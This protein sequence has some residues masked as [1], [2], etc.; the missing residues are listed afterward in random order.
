[1]CVSSCTSAAWRAS[2]STTRDGG[3]ITTTK[4]AGDVRARSVATAAPRPVLQSDP[5]PIDA[6]LVQPDS[7][8]GSIPHTDSRSDTQ[9]NQEPATRQFQGS[10]VPSV[11]RASFGWVWFGASNAGHWNSLRTMPWNSGTLEPWNGDRGA[12]ADRA[13]ARRRRCEMPHEMAGRGRARR[14]RP[15]RIDAARG[16]GSCERS[17]R[18]H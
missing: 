1:M 5:L 8:A 16:R 3:I 7:G 15:R 2:A 6:S 13:R 4:Q 10:N 11:P 17:V 9:Q 18:D 14:S 12:S